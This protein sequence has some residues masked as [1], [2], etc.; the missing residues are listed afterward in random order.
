M[1]FT[2]DLPADLRRAV[3]PGAG[4]LLALSGGVDSAV[5]LALLVELGADVTAVTFKNFCYGPDADPGGKSCCSLDAIED[6]RALA[7]RFGARHWV[8]DVSEAF[9]ARVIAPFIEAYQGAQTPNPCLACNSRVRFPHLLTLADQ[10]GCQFVATGHYA[11]TAPIASPHSRLQRGVDPAKDQAYFLAQVEPNVW[12]RVLFPVGGL[13]KEQV[14]ATAV[15]LG[16]AVARKPESQEI[17][18][19]PTGDR[20]FLFEASSA[21]ATPGEIVDRH[22]RVLGAHRGL[23]HYTVGQRRGLGV[24]SSRPLYVLGMEPGTNRLVVGFREELAVGTLRA[25][26]FSPAVALPAA[27]PPSDGGPWTAQIRHRHAGVPVTRW[28]WDG[29]GGLEVDLA[30]PVYGAAP[31]Q[32]LVLFAGDL[33]LG[34]GRLVAATPA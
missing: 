21:A 32:G 22:G 2:L 8:T 5:S 26:R 29:A 20:T 19:V 17:C 9:Q 24:A 28:R 15:A 13:R 18:F 31:G 6:A 33:V 12:P 10:L 23:L 30:A 25:D 7:A 3:T 27:G 34:G 1:S 11:R 14:R 16:L 4:V